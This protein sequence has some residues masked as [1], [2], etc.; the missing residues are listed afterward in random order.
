MLAKL[1]QVFIVALAYALALL[2]L[3]PNLGLI[4]IIQYILIATVFIPSIFLFKFR[5]W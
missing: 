4:N 1:R 2:N 3:I 5:L